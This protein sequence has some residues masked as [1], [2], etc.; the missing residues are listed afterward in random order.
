MAYFASR[1]LGAIRV[2]EGTN[3][4]SISIDLYNFEG[5]GNDV[6]EGLEFNPTGEEK[7]WHAFCVSYDPDRENPLIIIAEPTGVCCDYEDFTPDQVPDT[8]LANITTWLWDAAKQPEQR[9]ED[10]EED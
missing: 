7:V 3:N 9:W 6:C 2:H 4:A 8:T 5:D 1:P 10:N